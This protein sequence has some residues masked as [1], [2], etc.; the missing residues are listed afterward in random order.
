M[1][2]GNATIPG[3]ALPPLRS[4][5][6]RDAH[7]FRTFAGGSQVRNLPCRHFDGSVTMFSQKL[8]IERTT[9]MTCTR[10]N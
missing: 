10:G 9:L 7:V 4:N 1:F 3:V 6:Q 2:I 5:V 8:S